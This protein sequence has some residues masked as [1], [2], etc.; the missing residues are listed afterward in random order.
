MGQQPS[1]PRP[2]P[3]PTPAPGPVFYKVDN[4]NWTG[5]VI[6]S[7]GAEGGSRHYTNNVHHPGDPAYG[8]HEEFGSE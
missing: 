2:P 1:K 8:C 7:G 3:Q 6:D 5:S 4:G